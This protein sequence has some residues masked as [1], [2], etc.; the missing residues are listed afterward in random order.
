MVNWSGLEP[1]FFSDIGAVPREGGN[2]AEKSRHHAGS[3][4]QGV[5]TRE[6]NITV[7]KM[8]INSK[9]RF[10]VPMLNNG[11]RN[12]KSKFIQCMPDAFSYQLKWAI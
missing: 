11:N 2:A 4:S 12:T 8:Q 9:Q 1:D 6:N 10:S 3:L 5:A 7:K